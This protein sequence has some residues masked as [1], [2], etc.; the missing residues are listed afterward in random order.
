[1]ASF[2]AG[3]LNADQPEIERA[4]SLPDGHFEEVL[5]QCGD[6]HFERSFELVKSGFLSTI[7]Q[8]KKQHSARV[9]DLVLETAQRWISGELCELS[10]RVCGSYLLKAREFERRYVYIMRK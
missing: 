8:P 9:S 3:L 6:G 10:D 4:S 7:K 1:M 2:D 5:I